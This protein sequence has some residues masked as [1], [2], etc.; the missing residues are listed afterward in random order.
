MP[1]GERHLRRTLIEFVE[2]YYP[3]RN[4]QGLGNE[5]I[6]RAPPPQRVGGIR[7]RHQL[8]GLLNYYYRAA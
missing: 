7:R 2:Y 8:R 6:D 3:E 1:F 5:R 4:H